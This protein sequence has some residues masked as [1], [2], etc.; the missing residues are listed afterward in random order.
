MTGLTAGTAYT[1]VV[2]AVNMD[3]TSYRY[4]DYG[5][6]ISVTPT[7]T[8]SAVTSLTTNVSNNVTISYPD[9]ASVGTGTGT[10]LTVSWGVPN[11]PGDA[12]TI[13]YRV[14]ISGD[15]GI[16]WSTLSSATTSTEHRW[17]PTPSLAGSQVLFRVT[18]SNVAGAG[19]ASIVAATVP[20]QSIAGPPARPSPPTTL[21]ATRG[22]TSV[23]L[24]WAPPLATGGLPVTSYRL[25]YSTT[26]ASGYTVSSNNA[27]SPFTVTGLT[28]NTQYYFRVTAISAAGTGTSSVVSATPNGPAAAP[29]ALTYTAVAGAQSTLT[30]TAPTTSSNG[31]SLVAPNGYRVEQSTDDGANWT[32]LTAS[33]GGVTTLTVTPPA[34]GTTIRYRVAALTAAGLGDWEYVSATGTS[35]LVGVQALRA[36]VSGSNVTLNWDA[37]ATSG[38]TGYKVERCLYSSTTCGAYSVL[39][40]NQSTSTL[41]YTDATAV[42]QSVYGYRVTALSASNLASVL[43]VHVAG[44]PT[45]PATISSS[46]SSESATITW[47]APSQSP[48][49]TLLGYQ[50]EI[51]SSA[52]GAVGATYTVVRDSGMTLS[53]TIGGLNNGVTYTIRVAA[54][55]LLGV[56]SYVST[57]VTPRGA[58]AMPGDLQAIAGNGQVFLDWTAPTN[59]GGSAIL[60]YKI[61]YGTGSS[62][63][64]LNVVSSLSDP[65]DTSFMVTGL[66]NGTSYWFRVSAV[67]S[68]STSGGAL[69]S[70]IPVA[71][72]SAPTS[73]T[74]ITNA[75][76]PNA[77][78][79]NWG[80]PTSTGG[81]TI[82]GY[83]VEMSTDGTNWTVAQANTGLTTQ[84][85]V[86]GLT[87]GQ[88]YQFR[89]S[90]ITAAGYGAPAVV[91]GIPQFEPG[92]PL[93]TSVVAGDRRL[94]V[95]WSTPS[96]NGGSPITGYRVEL[97][98]ESSAQVCDN[99]AF[100]V[101]VSSNT[102]LVN[103]Y[104]ITGLTNGTLYGVRVSAV[105]DIGVSAF[106]YANFRYVLGR[107]FS[108]PIAPNFLYTTSGNRFLDLNWGGATANGYPILGYRIEMTADNGVSWSTVS[109]NTFSTSTSLRVNGLS[110][111]VQYGFRVSAVSYAGAGAPSGVYFGTPR[112]TSSGGVPNL[113]ASVGDAQVTLNWSSPSD[114]AGVPIVGYR[115]THVA[116]GVTTVVTENT[117]STTTN[118]TVFGLTN[119]TSY[120][121]N[122]FPVTSNG[123]SNAGTVVAR[124]QALSLAPREFKAQSR[125]RQVFLQWTAP[126][127]IGSNNDQRLFYRIESSEDGST[128]TRLTNVSVAA[129]SYLVTGLTNGTNYRFRISLVTTVGVGA[130]TMTSSTP[131][132][133]P[134]AVRNLAATAGD[135]AVTL[136]WDAP[137]DLGGGQLVGYRVLV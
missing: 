46:G 65:A 118:Y 103:S 83:R 27:T 21:S 34:N 81:Y 120:T 124:P 16:T 17:A 25:E 115:V 14:E 67:N 75:S 22:D 41:S 88:T 20:T 101:T 53:E 86:R 35:N 37:P 61:E 55:N 105:N 137:A 5:A 77:L 85:N 51:C 36:T 89:I 127:S 63:A 9:G 26:A 66:A 71:V 56:G 128:W 31:G 32:S 98:T 100:F 43:V 42:Y 70:A 113:R 91:S 80:T 60:G 23:T 106:G 121:F 102:G 136:T 59:T 119:G 130:S 45:A 64:S 90:A 116:G 99:D 104:T 78:F 7:A 13:S 29:T 76:I 1:F 57:T 84:W 126:S 40:A 15:G 19:V 73:A 28:N 131:F 82:A 117:L 132:G 94:T 38:A 10:Y 125:D 4:S 68:V 79:L 87:N 114:T 95:S 92:V 33:M 11:A 96:N 97:C 110:N 111:G 8:P 18:P 108:T 69:T 12:A 52:C 133:P 50:V 93:G 54:R 58:P 107:P 49:P 129:T 44:T 72:A 135:R 39:A 24:T 3:G 48:A 134:T 122:V 74:V 109:A 6:Q 62:L 123:Y 30:W 47:T 2:D 112:Q